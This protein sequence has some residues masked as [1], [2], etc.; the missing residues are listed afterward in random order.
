MLNA[1]G[2]CPPFADA[3]I[4]KI[5]GDSVTVGRPFA[6]ASRIG[7]TLTTFE[8]YTVPLH[9]FVETH[10]VVTHARGGAYKMAV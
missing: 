2:S 10:V 8:Q 5:E 1:D 6:Y 3:I 7:S 9:R 4:L